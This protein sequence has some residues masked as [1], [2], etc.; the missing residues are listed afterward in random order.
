MRKIYFLFILVFFTTVVKAQIVNI[1][2]ANFKNALVND[3]VYDLYCNGKIM[4]DVDT[5]DD[6]EIQVSEAEAV[7]CLRISNKNINSLEGIQSFINLTVLDCFNNNL[8]NIDISQNTALLSI[9]CQFTHL[10]SLD[11]TNNPNLY[12]ILCYSNNLTELDLTQNTDLR[13]LDCHNNHITELDVTQIPLLRVFICD[14]NN[15]E[16]L[17]VSQNQAQLIW[18]TCSANNLSFLNVQNG[19]NGILDW[20]DARYNQNDLCIQ[21]DDVVQANNEATWYKD[22]TAIYSEDCLLRTNDTDNVSE[23]SLYPNPV[24][25]FLNLESQN[26][27]KRV[28][29]FNLLGEQIFKVEGDINKIDF[30][31]YTKG[32]YFVK[33]KTVNRFQVKKVIKE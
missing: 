13:T 12:R 4:I 10:E 20:V 6:G 24:K 19:N 2:D 22:E 16:E 31:N 25:T 15:L 18:L 17:D 3:P 23:I 21:V 32:I 33:I 29:V 9:D 1:P 27:I 11:V 8:V 26:S 28:Q 5:N 7:E 14:G 30:S